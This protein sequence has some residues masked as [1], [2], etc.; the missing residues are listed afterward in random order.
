MFEHRAFEPCKLLN[1]VVI[2]ER[3]GFELSCSINS[4]KVP[5][6]DGLEIMPRGVF[7]NGE[8]IGGQ[9]TSKVVIVL[10]ESD[11]RAM[12]LS[13]ADSKSLEAVAEPGIIESKVW[14]E[15]VEPEIERLVAS[16]DAQAVRAGP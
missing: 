1:I 7:L 12:E 15:K 13:P 5:D 8:L 3:T 2:P 9:G 14:K 11:V 10:G 16:R 6:G 4:I